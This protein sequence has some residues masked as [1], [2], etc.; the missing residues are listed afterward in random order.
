M[1]ALDHHRPGDRG[2]PVVGAIFQ[3]EISTGAVLVAREATAVPG[4]DDGRGIGV[5][6]RIGYRERN[7]LTVVFDLEVDGKRGAVRQIPAHASEP[8]HALGEIS[9]ALALGP[10]SC[11]FFGLPE[12]SGHPTHSAL[13][14]TS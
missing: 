14:G 5:E 13:V 11:R 9:D 1:R 3:A 6:F 8:V 7:A 12:I 2:L 10:R 4:D